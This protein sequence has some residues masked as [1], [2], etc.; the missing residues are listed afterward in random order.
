MVNRLHRQHG[1]KQ[2]TLGATAAVLFRPKEAVDI[3]GHPF[4][5]CQRQVPDRGRLCL[6]CSLGVGLG[7]KSIQRRDES[8]KSGF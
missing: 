3:P 7:R 1:I 8:L 4:V 5:R 6:D 2:A